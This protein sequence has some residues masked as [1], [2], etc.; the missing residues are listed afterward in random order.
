MFKSKRFWLN[1][2]SVGLYVG[3]SFGFNVPAPDPAVV[4]VVNVVLQ[5][6]RVKFGI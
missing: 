6:L 5:V 2:A 3:Q 4:A 1:V